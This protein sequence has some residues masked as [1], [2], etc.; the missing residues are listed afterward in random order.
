MALLLERRGMVSAINSKDWTPLHVASE[1]AATL[2]PMR[3]LLEAG[4]DP[5]MT[6]GSGAAELRIARGDSWNSRGEG[7]V[8]QSSVAG[9]AGPYFFNNV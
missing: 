4:A 8:P 3:M 9:I 2:D 6:C 5:G 7:K 1:R